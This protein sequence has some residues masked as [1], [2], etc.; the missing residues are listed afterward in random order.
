M[1]W[2]SYKIKEE[3][4]MF[5]C[6]LY[7]KTYGVG[8]WISHGCWL[9]LSQP[10]LNRGPK[11]DS[12]AQKELFCP[13]LHATGWASSHLHIVVLYIVPESVQYA[14]WLCLISCPWLPVPTMLYAGPP[15]TSCAWNLLLSL[16]TSSSQ[17]PHHP[18]SLCWH[19]YWGV[20]FL[21]NSQMY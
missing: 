9:F 13:L 21:S 10:L 18:K 12:Y 7:L 20:C 8:P 19:A 6:L 3:G 5:F 14:R 4:L 2:L 17:P 16:H 1:R 11:C 15:I